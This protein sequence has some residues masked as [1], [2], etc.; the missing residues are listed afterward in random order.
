[1]GM[2]PPEGYLAVGSSMQK[3]PGGAMAVLHS[4]QQPNLTS[5]LQDEP[6]MT[7]GAMSEVGTCSGSS[8]SSQAAP[9]IW[10]SSNPARAALPIIEQSQMYARSHAHG[11]SL[12]I[13]RECAGEVPLLGLQRSSPGC[14]RHRSCM[15]S[16]SGP[17]TPLRPAVQDM[18]TEDDSM[19]VGTAL[20]QEYEAP[21]LAARSTGLEGTPHVGYASSQSS[22]S[23]LKG[24]PGSPDSPLLWAG[25]PSLP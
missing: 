13:L 21:H 16:Q 15:A 7:G 1:M 4:L 20:G 6:D 5:V 11:E 14:P 9:V 22:D 12:H 23:G 2:V 18:R 24:R 19:S 3:L 25:G 10:T 17:L 8:R